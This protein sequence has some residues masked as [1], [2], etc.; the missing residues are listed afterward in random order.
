MKW[1]FDLLSKRPALGVFLTVLTWLSLFVAQ[2]KTARIGTAFFDSLSWI[3]FLL[4]SASIL[5][6]G[7]AIYQK[8]FR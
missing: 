6:G 2:D 3:L 1:Y 7:M 4:L 8:F 5:L